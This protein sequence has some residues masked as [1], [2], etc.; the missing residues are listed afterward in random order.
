MITDQINEILNL[1]KLEIIKKVEKGN[2]GVKDV[3]RAGAR[4]YL[5]CCY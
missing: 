3:G 2:F 4:H 1:L 5:T